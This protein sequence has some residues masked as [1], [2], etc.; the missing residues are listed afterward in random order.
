MLF[1]WTLKQTSKRNE[2]RLSSYHETINI[3]WSLKFSA[4]K[5]PTPIFSRNKKP[6]SQIIYGQTSWDTITCTCMGL[7]LNRTS[8][9]PHPTNKVAYAYIQNFPEFQFN[10]IGRGRE[11][12]Q[13]FSKNVALFYQGTQKNVRKLRI[14]HHY[15]RDVCPGLELR[16]STIQTKLTSVNSISNTGK[17]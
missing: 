5:S 9:T 14:L 15:P 6:C 1:A 2:S 16:M 4:I 7:S 8:P 10:C 12:C 13:I 11:K 3:C 17:H